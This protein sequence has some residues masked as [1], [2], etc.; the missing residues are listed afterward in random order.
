MKKRVLSLILAL[1]MLIGVLPVN[2]LASG[3]E[4]TLPAQQTVTIETSLDSAL[5]DGVYAA[6]QS[7]LPVS[8]RAEADGEAVEHTASLDGEALT[9]TQAADGWTAYELS[10][11]AVGSYTLTVSAAGETQSRTIVYQPQSADE[12][13]AEDP[14]EELPANDSELTPAEETP[15]EETPAEEIPAE[16]PKQ[17]PK[18]VPQTA[19]QSSDSETAVDLGS[20]IGTVRVIVENNTA[21]TGAADTR[22]GTWEAGAAKWHGK[23]VDKE[24]TLYENSTAMTC[25]EEALKGYS[26]THSDS[27]VS[28]INGLKEG[29]AGGWMFT[30]NDWFPNQL[31]S[32]YRAGKELRSGD[33]ICMKYTCLGGSDVGSI[34]YDTNK[35][36]SSLTVTGVDLNKVDSTHYEI[37]LGDAESKSVKIVPTAYNK[38]FLACVFKGTLTDTQIDALNNDE[39]SWYTNTTLVRRNETV[40]IKEGD[41]FTVV[42]GAKSWPS[43]NNG[44][45]GGAEKV[46]P[47]VY[48]VTAVKTVTDPDAAFK[49]F[50]AALAGTATVANDTKDIEEKI[51]P[52][53]VAEDGTALVT[54]NKKIGK[55]KSGLTISFLKTAKLTFSY[56]T[57]SEAKWDYLKVYRITEA[58][59]KETETLLNEADK[60]AFSGEMSDYASY[61]VEVQAGEKIRIR[62]EKDF[63][64]DGTSDCVW[65][66]NF[67]VTLPNKVIF[68]AN[69]GTDATSEQGVF[70]TADLAKNTFTYAGYRF[71]GWAETA[72]GAVKYADGASITLNGADVNLYAVWTEVWNV[73]FPNMPKDAAIT[74]KQGETI[75]PVSETA[76][77]WILPNGSYTYSAELFGYESKENVP[78]Q[79]NGANLEI[80]DTLTAADKI[81]VTFYVTGAAADTAITITVW[82][83]EKTVMTAREANP[84]VYDL[85]A[86][87]YTYTVEA[88]GYKKIKNQLL[89]VGAA[90]QTVNVALTASDAWEGD[91]VVPTKVGDVYQITSGAEL[92][93]FADLV[94]GEEPGAKGILTK[95]ITLNEPGDYAQKWTPMGASSAAAFT[96]DFDGNGKTITGLYMDGED[97]I[98]GLFGYVGKT[99]SIHDLT[100]A[101]ASVKSTKTSYGVYTA[102]VAASNAGTISNVALKDSMVSSGGYAGGIAALNDGTI[103]G[104]ANESAPV[105]HNEKAT[106][107]YYALA[108]GIAGQNRG[109]IALSYNLARVTGGK[110]N[111]GHIGGI[112]GKNE[113]AGTIESCYNRGDIQTG[114]YLGGITG[115]LSGTATNCYSTGSVP[116]GTYAKALFGHCTSYSAKATAC[117]YLTGCGPEDTKGTAKTAEKFKT[118]AASLGG[119][120]AD[121]DP[122]PTLKWQDPNATFTITLTVKPA[123]ASVTVTGAASVGTPEVRKNE[124][125]NEATY[126]YS[127]LNKGNYR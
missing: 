53:E 21:D 122:Y 96:G 46:N 31:S 48:T 16:E 108:G 126:I 88:K 62:F 15:A 30:L 86:G 58:A 20:A 79:V 93:G 75:Q 70:G 80:Q 109:T 66:K 25:L 81:A 97:A 17:A 36:L 101:D 57:S 100:I 32:Y 118:L 112:A 85:P 104:C 87:S 63:S 74:V 49:N 54:T 72:G 3:A 2:V 61:S 39:N 73:M 69:N 105:T 34:A 65:L 37:P 103:T 71:D 95:N 83:S 125:T 119:A 10:F 50:F 76:N 64:G 94:N 23:L 114:A 106:S 90:A 11:E 127:G 27:Y 28:A 35:T 19:A 52:L 59:G 91:S 67:T 43:Q 29:G 40:T 55:S 22:Y 4:D 12:P 116:T 5:A 44:T 111:I 98:S 14:A 26:M 99:G 77:T 123:N 51:Y 33:E 56:K 89:T 18:A 102:L 82:N 84:T 47:G 41:T 92:K 115:Y 117:F 124:E 110:E 7:P 121:A 78:F 107:S 42:V 113:S 60:E 120:F 24:V 38:N 68:H 9:G 13:A 1:V 8:I 45:Y 6:A